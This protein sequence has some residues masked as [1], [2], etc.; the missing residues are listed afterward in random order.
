M[1]ACSSSATFGRD[2]TSNGCRSP[3][4]TAQPS[5]SASTDSGGGCSAAGVSTCG[6]A[7][8]LVESSVR[9]HD[10]TKQ[11]NSP[12]RSESAVASTSTGVSAGPTTSHTPRAI[13]STDACTPR[14]TRTMCGHRERRAPP[15]AAALAA[16]SRMLL[17]LLLLPPPP[18]SRFSLPV[19][20]M[21]QLCAMVVS[22]ESAHVQRATTA[23]GAP[24]S[25]AD[26]S[27]T[28][29]ASCSILGVASRLT[30]CETDRHRHASRT[31]VS[32]SSCSVEE[33]S[34]VGML[35]CIP[36]RSRYS[37]SSDVTHS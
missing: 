27:R 30:C 22:T 10:A 35:R 3:N 31:S 8:S 16:T 20:P 12:G 33:S 36:P 23:C 1:H 6:G 28:A 19:L 13:A 7:A 15:A 26:I 32:S 5:A 24:C 4:M 17:L 9:R 14:A 18:P 25:L 37:A 11:H 2:S 34:C 29:P 21:R